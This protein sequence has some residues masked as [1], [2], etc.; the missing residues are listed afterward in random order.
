MSSRTC[1]IG[2]PE[3]TV[4]STPARACELSPSRR[5]S[6]W[7]ILIRTCLAGSHQSKLM[8]ATWR[9]AAKTCA[10]LSAMSQTLRQPQR[11]VAH[12]R[13]LRAADAVLDRPSDRRTQLQCGDTA[14]EAG[15]LIGQHLFELLLQAVARGHVLGD[16]HG[17]AEEIVRKL[18]V[19]GQI[20]PDRT[21]A[22]IG[23]PA[24]DIRIF[25]EDIVNTTRHGFAGKDR[26]ILGQRQVDEQFGSIRGREEL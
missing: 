17:L 12:L 26:G 13:N 25:L 3:M 11:A 19:E 18:H 22:D 21:A 24:R 23:A 8:C 16:D 9:F 15:E 5:A 6:F 20:E 4:L 7:S 14:G 2:L 10:S 1:V